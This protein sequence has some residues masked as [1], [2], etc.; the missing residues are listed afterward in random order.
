[1]SREVTPRSRAAAPLTSSMSAWSERWIATFAE[2]SFLFLTSS[3]SK[4]EDSRCAPILGYWCPSAF[5][6]CDRTAAASVASLRRLPADGLPSCQSYSKHLSSVFVSISTNRNGKPEPRVA[7]GASPVSRP[8]RPMDPAGPMQTHRTAFCTGPWTALKNA[9]LT[10]STGRPRSL[11][12]VTNLT[13]L[14]RFG[15]IECPTPDQ[16]LSAHVDERIGECWATVEK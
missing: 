4:T 8:C 5:A 1:M 9:P 15:L 6:A 13:G 12:P 7:P 10:G 14:G 3:I 16:A 2:F 11:E